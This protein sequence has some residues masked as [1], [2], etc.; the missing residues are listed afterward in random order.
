MDLGEMGRKDQGR[1][2]ER[3]RSRIRALIGRG[4]EE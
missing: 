1:N 4:E 3:D 2:R